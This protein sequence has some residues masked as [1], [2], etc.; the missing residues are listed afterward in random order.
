MD[1][2]LKSDKDGNIKD[3]FIQYIESFLGKDLQ[4]LPHKQDAEAFLERL[5]SK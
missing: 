4:F 3:Y 5:K 1:E 2:L